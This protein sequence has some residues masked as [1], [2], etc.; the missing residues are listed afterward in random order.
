MLNINAQNVIV[1]SSASGKFWGKILRA[2]LLTET[3]TEEEP[4]FGIH[5][6][7]IIQGGSL[8]YGCF[9][10]SDFLRLLQSM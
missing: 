4:A 8:F 1:S 3:K 6:P 9:K 2:I 7:K 10:S 5:H